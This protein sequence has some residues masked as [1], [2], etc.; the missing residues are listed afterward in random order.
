AARLPEVDRD[1]VEILENAHEEVL[2]AQER[3]DKRFA[4]GRAQQKLE[5]ARQ[6]EQEILDRLGFL[7][8]TEFLLGTSIVNVDPEHEKRLDITR[9]VLSSAEDAVAALEADV[10][11][12]LARAALVARRN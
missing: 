9:A 1:D 12:E 10:D 11:A 5:E 8:Y 4:G 6:A 7:S 2:V 3:L